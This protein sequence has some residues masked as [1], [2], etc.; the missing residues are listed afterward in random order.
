MTVAG[1]GP[2]EQPSLHLASGSRGRG[3]VDF[4]EAPPIADPLPPRRSTTHD[5]SH[6]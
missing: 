3:Q 5:T 1:G 6:R 4:L 2:M